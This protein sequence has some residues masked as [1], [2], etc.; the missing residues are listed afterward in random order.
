MVT[1]ADGGSRTPDHPVL[2]RALC[3]TWGTPAYIVDSFLVGRS[4]SK[5][6]ELTLEALWG[7]YG[8]NVIA[9]RIGRTHRAVVERA[10]KLG[11]GPARQDTMTLSEFA[12]ATGYSRSRLKT[13]AAH[14]GI[15]LKRVPRGDPRLLAT[16]HRWHAI[17]FEDQ[18]RI[19]EY[20]KC[21]PDA[22]KLCKAQQGKWGGPSHRGGRKPSRC[23]DC[24]SNDEPHFCRGRCKRCDQRWRAGY[25]PLLGLTIQRC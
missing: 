12:A 6:E 25:A 15:R 9:R 24:G 13:A 11:L 10:H 7:I 21:I 2:S 1:G 5:Q 22:R 3:L 18:E 16:H 4:W 8:A 17:S 20:L 23:I 14:L 19:L